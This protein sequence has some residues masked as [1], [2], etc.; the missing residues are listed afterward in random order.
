LNVQ[1]RFLEYPLVRDRTARRI[2][3]EIKRDWEPSL[4]GPVDITKVEPS[5]RAVIPSL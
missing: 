2:Y 5:N 4:E 3:Q 1:A